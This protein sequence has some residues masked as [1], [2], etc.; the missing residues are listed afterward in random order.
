MLLIILVAYPAINLIPVASL[1]GVMFV[2]TYFTVEW[3]SGFVLL[4]SV[5]PMKYRERFGL[6]TKVKRTDLMTSE[7]GGRRRILL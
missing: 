3:E 2:V 6:I 7:G 1:A 4:G 5:L